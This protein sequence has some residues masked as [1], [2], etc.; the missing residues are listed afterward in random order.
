MAP[1]ARS[2]PAASGFEP[3]SAGSVTGGSLGAPSAKRS[4]M[5]AFFLR[6]RMADSPVMVSLRVGRPP[7]DIILLTSSWVPQQRTPVSKVLKLARARALELHRPYPA[8]M[9]A[10]PPRSS[11]P[12]FFRTV[13][14]QTL[15]DRSKI[16]S[17]VLHWGMVPETT[18]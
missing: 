14:S 10:P 7:L 12:P 5:G 15:P 8:L 18:T 16:P 9:L 4:C 2:W 11:P 13:H 3:T 6:F 1:A 17:G